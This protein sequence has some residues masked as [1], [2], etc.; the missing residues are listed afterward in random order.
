MKGKLTISRLSSNHTD[1]DNLIRIQL[2]DKTSGVEFLEINLS[3]E[4]FALALTGLG[5]QECEFSLGGLDVI[6]KRR[7]VKDEVVNAPDG[8]SL[9]KISEEEKADLLTPYCVDGW[10]VNNTR[11]L[12]NPHRRVGDG[13]RVTFIRFVDVEEDSGND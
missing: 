9:S 1:M 3:P 12:G 10:E 2:K 6:G 4:Q 13:Y 8:L 7:Q 11:D 5:Y